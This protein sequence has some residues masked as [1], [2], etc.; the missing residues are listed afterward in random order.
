ML[1]PPSP[2]GD[3][4]RQHRS[5][6][7]VKFS[8]PWWATIDWIILSFSKTCLFAKDQFEFGQQIQCAAKHGCFGESLE[9]RLRKTTVF[10]RMIM[11]GASGTMLSLDITH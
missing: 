9:A 1:C 2:L 3:A 11:K 7:T 5:D 4:D 6:S 8:S 10:E